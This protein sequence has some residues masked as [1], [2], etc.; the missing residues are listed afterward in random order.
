MPEAFFALAGNEKAGL[1]TN[2]S[3]F[4]FGKHA[5][6][7]FS[8]CRKRKSMIENGNHRHSKSRILNDSI[9]I[10]LRSYTRAV[11]NQENRSGNIFREET[12]AIC[13]N[14]TKGISSDWHTSFGETFSFVQ[15]PECQYPQVCLN[16]IHANPVKARLVEN[17]EEWEFASYRALKESRN[18]S[19]VNSIRVRELGLIVD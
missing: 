2:S 5:G 17:P 18:G 7:R 16:Y 4:V 15:I 19:L 3:N 6:N 9:G 13:L 14:E 12:K 1:K 8:P 10:M 11:N